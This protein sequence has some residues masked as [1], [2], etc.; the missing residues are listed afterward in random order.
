[1]KEQ[2]LSI[3]AWSGF[4]LAT[5]FT[6][7]AIGLGFI[8]SQIDPSDLSDYL[9]G[10]ITSLIGALIV[11]K[12]RRNPIGWVAL[13]IGLSLAADSIIV[14][15]SPFLLPQA[16]N[17]E[18]G[19]VWTLWLFQWSW[20][21]V[22]PG[23]ILLLHLFP[24]GQPLS[25]RWR[26][27]MIVSILAYLSII[28]FFT[29][30]AP[31][32]VETAQDTI[33]E[34]PSPFGIPWGDPELALGIFFIG[35]VVPQVLGLAAMLFRFVRARGIERQQMKW[36]LFAVSVYL[37]VLLISFLVM[38]PFLD[39]LIAVAALGMPIAIGIAIFRYRLYD[40]DILIRRTITYALVTALLLL[41]YFGSVIFLQQVVSALTGSAQN[42]IVTVLST[43]AI[44]AL[45]VPLRNRVQV[46]IDKY[47]NRKKYD[48]Q[49]VLNDFAKTVRDETDLEK[50]T[51]RL[52]QVV[53]ETMQPKSVSVW[54]RNDGERQ[55]RG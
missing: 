30:I 15:Y 27:V 14:A 28:A 50:L 55:P 22:I 37:L 23:I 53:D 18:P 1:M 45:F 9:N 38:E 39:A 54:L 35:L 13:L 21:G 26:W 12:R 2:V 10:V 20:G 51:A 25:P 49:K 47:F 17:Q 52:I 46:E 31:I 29:V 19:A 8:T 32:E 3:L 6:L 44:A 43:L 4:A 5:A 42:E 16:L 7:G 34:I 36:F 33:V 40:I 48:A 24:T 11:S 41:I